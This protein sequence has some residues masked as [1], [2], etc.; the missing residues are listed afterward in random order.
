MSRACTEILWTQKALL[1]AEAH[2]AG[3][4]YVQLNCD[5]SI[6]RLVTIA[7]DSRCLVEW[8]SAKR[9]WYEQCY[10]R[11]PIGQGTADLTFQIACRPAGLK[12]ASGLGDSCARA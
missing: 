1:N 7:R 8:P 5:G 3:L 11:L 12:V 6:V 9:E 10:L 2:A 4:E